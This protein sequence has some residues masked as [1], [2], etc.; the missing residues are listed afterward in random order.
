MSTLTANRAKDALKAYY[1]TEEEKEKK[2][3]KKKKLEDEIDTNDWSTLESQE[4]A[5]VN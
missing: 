2:R 1:E 4:V 5:G 3:K